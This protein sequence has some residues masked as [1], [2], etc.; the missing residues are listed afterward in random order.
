MQSFTTASLPTWVPHWVQQWP[1][2]L[3]AGALGGLP[4][5]EARLRGLGTEG[6]MGTGPNRLPGAWRGGVRV[7]QA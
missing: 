6:I 5:G 4:L 1:L 7:W 2:G 3:G